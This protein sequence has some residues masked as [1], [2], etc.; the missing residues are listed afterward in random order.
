MA[1]MMITTILK[2]TTPPCRVGSTL[3]IFEGVKFCNN[4]LRL[5]V[6]VLG[7]QEEFLI[8]PKGL[9]CLHKSLI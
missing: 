7:L 1:T 2:V 8:S 3:P 5:S 4:V 6:F 9:P